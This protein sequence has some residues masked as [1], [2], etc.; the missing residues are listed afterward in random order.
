MYVDLMLFSLDWYEN[1]KGFGFLEFTTTDR[2]R[3]LLG[4][5]MSRKVDFESEAQG[6]HQWSADLCW[7]RFGAR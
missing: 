6:P 7:R 5:F 3:A 2:R 4:V 1:G